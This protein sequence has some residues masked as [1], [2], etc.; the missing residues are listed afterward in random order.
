MATCSG[1]FVVNVT[2]AGSGWQV[3]VGE[4]VTQLNVIVPVNPGSAVTTTP[5]GNEPPG[6]T[7]PK[8]PPGGGGIVSVI[9]TFVT[10][11]SAAPDTSVPAAV[12]VIVIE[13]SLSETPVANPVAA[14]IVATSVSDEVQLEVVVMSLVVP[15]EKCPVAVNCIFPRIP[16]SCHRQG[17]A[18]Q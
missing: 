10:V 4:F 1:P 11:S 18:S 15:S 12:A 3:I 13:P 17:S 6:F 16:T 5:T 9:G 7:G 2:D 14:L 8:L